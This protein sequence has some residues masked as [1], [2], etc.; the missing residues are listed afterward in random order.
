MVTL[1]VFIHILSSYNHITRVH[2][3]VFN[4]LSPSIKVHILLTTLHLFLAKSWENLLKNQDI[5]FLVLI[6]FSSHDLCV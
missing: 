6:F 3:K 1:K 5:L 2:S 4:P